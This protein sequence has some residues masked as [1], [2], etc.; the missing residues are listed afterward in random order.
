MLFS[1]HLNGWFAI[2]RTMTSVKNNVPVHFSPIN[3]Q[4]S[5]P[6]NIIGIVQDTLC[7]VRK[8]TKRDVFIEKPDM[9]NLLM[10]LPRW[11]GHMP[12]P[13]IIKPTP[14]WTGKQLF[15]LIIPGKINCIR[16]VRFLNIDW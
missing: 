7:A 9:M 2:P 12:M 11:N 15:S 5:F 4:I 6:K 14:L 1:H 8:M 13:A 10:Q 3:P 16:S